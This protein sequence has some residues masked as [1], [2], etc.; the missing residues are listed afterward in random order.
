MTVACEVSFI[1][2]DAGGSLICQHILV[3]SEFSITVPA[4]EVVGVPITT[5]GFGVGT[6]EDELITRGTARLD[7]LCVVS[8]AVEQVLV[9]AVGQINK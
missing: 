4:T 2:A 3:T 5:H 6:R 1:A 8:L 9:D 7:L